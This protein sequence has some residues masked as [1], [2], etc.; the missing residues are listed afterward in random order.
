VGE[1]RGLGMV[2]ALE[3]VQN[4]DP[5]IPF[6]ERGKVGT[7][8][9]DLCVKNGLIMRAVGDT[10]IISPPLVITREQIDELVDRARRSLD[11]TLRAVRAGI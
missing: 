11:D 2:G 7:L 3:L 8:C 5:V 6:A 1:A 10:M 4:R 9:R